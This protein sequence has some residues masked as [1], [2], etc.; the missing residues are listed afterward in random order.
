MRTAV[1]D[2]QDLDIF[3]VT[4][5][6]DLLVFDAQ[7]RKVDLLVEVRQVMLMCP[8]FDFAAVAIGVSVVVITVAIALVKSGLILTLELVVQDDANRSAHCALPGALLHVRTPDT[9]ER[10]ARAPARV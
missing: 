9:P 4:A 8:L 10:R 1:V 6:V 5:A 3:V 7:I 2:G